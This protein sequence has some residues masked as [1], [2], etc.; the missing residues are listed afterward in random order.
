M[1]STYDFIVVGGGPS[2]CA[3]ASTLAKSPKKPTI[4]L[5]EAG[6]K[7]DNHNFRVDGQRWTTFFNQEMNWGYKTT[8]QE[9]CGNREIDLPGGRGLGGGS[10]VNFAGYSVGCRD[11]YDEWAR[12]VGDDDFRWER[13]QT[14]FKNLESFNG[15]P[16]SGIDKKY[17]APK[18]TD[19]GTSG[20]LKVGYAKECVEDLTEMLDCFE[21]AGFPLNSDH[22]SGNP[23]G[24]SVA[25]SSCQNG[26]RSTAADLITPAPD[27]LTVIVNS[28]V[29]RV[30]IENKKAI[31]VESNGKK[32]FASK[33]VILCAGAL[34]SPRIL[35][36]SGIGP[37]SQLTEYKIPITHANEA[38]GQNMR[39]HLCVPIVHS[40]KEPGS[41]SASFYGSTQAM[42][43][44]MEQWKKDGTGPWAIHGSQAGIGF[45]KMAN[46]AETKEFQDL[47]AEEQRFILLDTVPHYEVVTH[48]PAHWFDPTL[49]TLNYHGIVTWYF[50]AQSRGEITLQSSDPDVPL[51]FDSKFLTAPF[52]RRVAIESLRAVL[53]FTEHESYAKNTV[54][55]LSGPKSDSDEDIMEHWSQKVISSLHM[56][57]TARMGK[58]GDSNV[59]V[60]N[61]FR[62]IGIEGLCVADL[63]AVPV[64]PSAH[65]QAAAYVTGITC[66]EKLVKEFGLE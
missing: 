4:L 2:G 10:A 55:M 17:A 24:M 37:A 43:A 6:G 20:P 31:G 23:I 52:D 63:S 54:A 36:H 65:V 64:L 25:I 9:H 19:H 44:A 21:Q 50:N 56:T 39:D 49:P 41:S 61:N 47:P 35:M 57:G 45:F 42:D 1:T 12:I 26:V 46:I 8:P 62:V 11:D 18:A 5:L 28:L 40:R 48:F 59:V 34:N 7:N 29:Q 27:N 33:K 66:A 22:N 16:P 3:I 32:Y 60:D 58:P 51:K 15:E 14:R 13:M 53:R 38:V 30:I